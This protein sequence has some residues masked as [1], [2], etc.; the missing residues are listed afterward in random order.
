MAAAFA[1]A[2]DATCPLCGDPI[3]SIRPSGV[4]ESEDLH[5][6]RLSARSRPGEGYMLCDGCGLL[7]E[8]PPGL[9]MN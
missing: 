5:P 8:L 9:T 2:V 1:F 4:V 6:V 3:L 7:A